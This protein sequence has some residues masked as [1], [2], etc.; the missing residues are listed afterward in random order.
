M[1]ES[2]DTTLK[3]LGNLSLMTGLKTWDGGGDQDR[4]NLESPYFYTADHT[5]PVTK[6]TGPARAL[7]FCSPARW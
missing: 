7:A 2:L 3:C 4:W 6:S 5:A 1:G